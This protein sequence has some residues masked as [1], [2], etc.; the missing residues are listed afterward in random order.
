M[1]R[2]H[3]TLGIFVKWIARGVPGE[4]LNGVLLFGGYKAIMK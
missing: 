3:I 1:D 2:G 4:L